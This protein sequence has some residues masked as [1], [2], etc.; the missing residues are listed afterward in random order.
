[1]IFYFRIHSAVTTSINA[2]FGQEDA[3]IERET[4]IFN[5]AEIWALMDDD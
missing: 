1:M 5:T 2:T 4:E 3:N